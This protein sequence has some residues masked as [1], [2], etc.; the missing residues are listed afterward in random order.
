MNNPLIR[1]KISNFLLNDKRYNGKFSKV[2][3]E[4]IGFNVQ[5]DGVCKAKVWVLQGERIGFNARKD[6]FYEVKAMF[7]I[8]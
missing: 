6:R 2:A 7:S 8:W 3:C 5:K 1:C 4:R